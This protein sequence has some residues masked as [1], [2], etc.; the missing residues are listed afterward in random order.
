MQPLK[1]GIAYHSNRLFSYVQEDMKDILRHNF[2]LV[3]HMFSHNDW[4]R[5]PSVMKDIF[6]YTTDLGLEFWVDNWGLAG[7]PGDPS[8]FM[9][10]HP[11]CIQYF[12]TGETRPAVC[13]NQPAFVS[14]TKEWIDMVYECGG[15]KIFWDEPHL[16]SSS[17]KFGCA[18]PL[19]KKIFR[20]K[21]GREMP[22][23]PDAD[24]YAFQEWTILHYFEQ[25]T[26][27]SRLRGMENIVCVMPA[28]PGIGHGISLDNM[29]AFGTME[30]VDNIGTDPYWV[31]RKMPPKKPE[32]IYKFVY[33][34]ARKNLDVCAKYGKDHNLWIQGYD[35][36]YGTEEDVVYAADAAYEAGARNILVWG[37]RGCEGNEYRSDS[38]EMTWK[39]IGD[40]FGRIKNK[41]RDRI[42]TET[43]KKL[44]IE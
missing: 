40:A 21:Y 12:S 32:E 1:L 2:N 29:D 4:R 16:P 33:E 43:R 35:F 20:E 31:N 44:G 19:C 42:I 15:R 8:H 3:V 25:V 30:T 26:A 11:E 7:S 14:W 23:T 18:C 37:H 28:P 10:Y 34:S 9:S 6:Q 36:P 41:E 13:L 39:A 24:V 22:V 5:C 17:E 38:P 27:Y